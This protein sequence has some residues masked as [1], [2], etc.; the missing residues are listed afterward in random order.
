MLQ[1]TNISDPSIVLFSHEQT[2]KLIA[3]QNIN[4]YLL[5][6]SVP[7]LIGVATLVS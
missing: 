6:V 1:M 2:L 5:C 4:F 3:N 7:R